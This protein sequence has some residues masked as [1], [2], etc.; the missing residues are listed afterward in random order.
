MH[1]HHQTL[2]VS[3][4]KEDAFFVSAL[5]GKSAA[6][7]ELQK[8]TPFLKKQAKKRAPEFP[9]D[10]IDEVICE[11]WLIA[12]AR[13]VAAFDPSRGSACTYLSCI[14][15]EAARSVRAKYN[16]PG[17]ATRI[18]PGS[19]DNGDGNPAVFCSS[20]SIDYEQ[21]QDQVR[22]DHEYIENQV[23]ACRILERIESPLREYLERVYLYGETGKEVCVDLGI[24]RFKI[25]RLLVNL[26]NRLQ[27]E[28]AIVTEVPGTIQ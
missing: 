23:D 22:F 14:I 18:R 28:L 15:R 19:D 10:L 5:S 11:M 25:R 17:Q 3:Y 16:I 1:E 7:A 20:L 27:Q 6:A 12:L 4:R 2:A 24:S 21:V 8:I 13:G 26:R 9:D